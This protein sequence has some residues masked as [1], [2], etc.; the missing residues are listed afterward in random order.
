MRKQS[1]VQGLSKGRVGAPEDSLVVSE[2]YRSIQGESSFAGYPCGFVRLTGCPLRCVWC[3]SEFA[4]SGGKVMTIGEIL[5]EVRALG[6]NLIEV[7]G[8]EP[9]AQP[10]CLDLLVRLCDAGYEVLLETSGSID[11][12]PVDPRVIKIMDIKC[13]GSGEEHR[14]RLENIDRLGPRDE[15]KFV[16]ADR[17]DYEWAR[18]FIRERN[19]EQ[20]GGLLLSPV[21]GQLNSPDLARWIQEDGLRARLQI[22]LHKYLWPG[23]DRGI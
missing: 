2:L 6:V 7:T 21:H 19:L 13:P 15:I 3:D 17:A 4:F 22:Q 8:G 14:N 10:R 1:T 5:D 11:V 9:L 12:A 18:D 23:Q 16:L 20:R